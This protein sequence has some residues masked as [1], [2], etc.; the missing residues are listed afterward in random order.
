MKT[1]PPSIRVKVDPANPGQFF[2]CCGLLELAD[3]IRPGTEGRF[4]NDSFA[5]FGAGSLRDLLT[6][7]KNARLTAIE[8]E[9]PTTTPLLLPKP[10]DLRLDWWLD[11]R[12]GGSTFKT[13]AG[14]QKVVTIAGAMQAAVD[15]EVLDGEQLMAASAILYGPEAGGDKIEPFYLD[16]R[17]AAQSHSLDVGFSP[18]AQKMLMPVFSAVEF[19]CLVGLQRFRP[20]RI[21][22]ENAFEYLAWR[23]ALPVSVASAAAC[24]CI[25]K[26]GSRYRFQLLYRT[27][28]LKGFLPA[29]R[30]ST[31]NGEKNYE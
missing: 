7:L 4:E 10:I 9:N 6:S 23:D 19:L 5:L 31:F 12:A 22:T 17:R 3:K 13:W 27:K 2:A 15:P 29:I 8:P 20:L 18:D 21:E 25:P 16:A 30:I 11:D 14:Q 24:A 28:Y 1:T 26:P